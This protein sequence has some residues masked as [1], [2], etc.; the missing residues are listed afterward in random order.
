MILHLRDLT[1]LDLI[2]VSNALPADEI[3]QEFAFTG[4]HYTAEERAARCWS[5]GGPR[6]T[7]ADADERA[8][9]VGGMLPIRH[10]VF[11]TWF[12]AT[13]AAWEYGREITNLVR[14]VKETQLRLAAH[15][16][17]TYCLA[18]REPA[19]AWYTML[20]LKKEA[21]LTQFCI[22]GRDAALYVALREMS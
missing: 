5:Y 20:G 12:F 4:K 17:E 1:L 18:S 6:W 2:V 3:D 7:I 14:S 13:P 10:A 11:E 19:Q 9:A 8:V 15:R 21:T 16:I 22:D